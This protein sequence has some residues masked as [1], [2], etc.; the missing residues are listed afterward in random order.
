MDLG[1]SILSRKNWAHPE[2]GHI[3]IKER[4]KGTV[5]S[6]ITP[7]VVLC[8]NLFILRFDYMNIF[9]GNKLELKL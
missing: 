1:V 6:I 3:V 8:L 9:F 4:K 5:V 7:R 2:E